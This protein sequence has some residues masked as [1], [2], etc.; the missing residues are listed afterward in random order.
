[1]KKKLFY[2][3]P[4]AELIELKLDANVMQTGS[5]TGESFGDQS[6]SGDESDWD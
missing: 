2:E 5:P 3:A 1:M 4:D 6:G